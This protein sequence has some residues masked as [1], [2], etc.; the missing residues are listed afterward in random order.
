MGEIIGGLFSLFFTF[1]WIFG[2]FM[3]IK[4]AQKNSGKSG[5][6]RNSAQGSGAAGNTYK[7]N[8]IGTSNQPAAYGG[9]SASQYSSASQRNPGSSAPVYSGSSSVGGNSAGRSNVASSGGANRSSSGNGSSAMTYLSMVDTDG[10]GKISTTEYLAE[11]ARE[12]EAEH[13]KDEYMTKQK[14]T[15][16]GTLRLGLRIPDDGV[17]PRGMRIVYCGYC[18]AD[19]VVPNGVSEKGF[20]CYFCHEQL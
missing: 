19:N 12:D 5:Q 10:D 4:A 15:Q 2:I 13:R 18:G 6:N 9:Q 11:K 3:V 14:L 16:G 17:I 1:A 8:F 20:H 7:S